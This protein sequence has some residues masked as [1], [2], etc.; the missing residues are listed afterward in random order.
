MRKSFWIVLALLVLSS[1]PLAR[2][3]S[4]DDFKYVFG[5]N[6]YTWQLPASPTPNATIP[7]ELFEMDSISYA[8]NGVTQTTPGIFDFFLGGAQ[9]GG[10]LLSQGSSTI[11][12]T[13]GAQLFKGPGLTNPTFL[14]GSFTLNN[15]SSTGPTGTLTISSATP[16]PASLELL[17]LGLLTFAGMVRRKR[18][19]L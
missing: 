19:A 6:T 8:V 1:A 16:E 14:L 2:A 5:G 15:G 7:L 11:L 12:A 9:G 13:Y 17:G 4:V 10:F 3:N 18:F